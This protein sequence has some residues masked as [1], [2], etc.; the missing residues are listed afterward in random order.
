MLT[1]KLSQNMSE[2]IVEVKLNSKKILVVDDNPLN[3]K[4]LDEHFRTFGFQIF[5]SKSGAS[6]IDICKSELPDIVLLD[7]MMPLM[8]GFQVID[9]LKKD[10]TTSEI[11]IIFLTARTQTNDIIK[12]FNKGAVDY[13]MK[14]FN[15]EELTA[16]VNTHLKMKEMM[17]RLETQNKKLIELNNE[18]NHF[19]GIAA[20][21]MKNP[22]FSISMLAKSIRDDKNI[23]R[24][25]VEDFTN[26]I[27]T[28]SDRMLLLIKDLL[29]I[30]AIEQGLMKFNI[31]SFD[32]LE[33]LSSICDIYTQ[34]ANLKQIK[35]HFEPKNDSY[36]INSDR[37]A[38]TQILD[39][40]LS[41][42]IKFSPFGKN[43]VLEILD[44][45]N[46]I[47][48]SVLDEGPGISS[49]DML[50]LFGKFT[51]LSALPTADESSTGLG[52]S[53]AKQYV[54]ALCGKIWCESI[55]GQGAKFIFELPKS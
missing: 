37:R 33:N 53:I 10:A 22:I 26:D 44:F 40:L 24:E 19:L 35:L 12:G 54:E 18:K 14:P 20:H 38:I 42:A 1:S 15:P 21:D 45:E 47:Q 51:K 17:V 29:D 2:E 7:I 48:I 28:T 46:K 55:L 6:A 8:D 3:L 16:R 23:N 34:N 52:L 39:N 49:E 32:L 25:D 41:N 5:V 4:V 50:K 36:I 11:P 27:I 43:I 13:I 30:N 31:E 9:E